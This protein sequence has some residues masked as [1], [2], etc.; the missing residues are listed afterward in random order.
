MQ[1]RGVQP[2]ATYQIRLRPARQLAGLLRRLFSILP[3][4]GFISC[5][6]DLDEVGLT[7]Q[8]LDESEHPEFTR[9]SQQLWPRRRGRDFL[10]LALTDHVKEEILRHVDETRDPI[11]VHLEV[12]C[13][14]I[15]GELAVQMFDMFDDIYV[16]KVVGEA[17][18]EAWRAEGL[19]KRWEQMP[20]QLSR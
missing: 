15:G 6:G 16:R 14:S 13:I 12:P 3:D 19:I 2:E 1:G 5:E 9:Q 20:E 18:L 8:G 11:G 4:G 7:D 10:V 17:T